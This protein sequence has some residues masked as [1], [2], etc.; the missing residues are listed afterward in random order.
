MAS[1]HAA[2][3]WW[4]GT[5]AWLACAGA[6]GVD[7]VFVAM[8]QMTDGSRPRAVFV[9]AQE[10]GR[11]KTEAAMR[12]WDGVMDGVWGW[13]NGAWGSGEHRAGRRVA[14]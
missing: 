7:G 2:P 8:G 12:T 5:D 11:G 9:V 4:S 6:A 1:P 10:E 13:R 3:Q 14:Y